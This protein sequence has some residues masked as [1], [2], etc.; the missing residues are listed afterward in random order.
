MRAQQRGRGEIF[1]LRAR[2][3][4]QVAMSCLVRP[5]DLARFGESVALAANHVEQ[6]HL[7]QQGD[8]AACVL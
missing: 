8:S 6:R 2:L 7:V 1:A 5:R 4:Q 3:A